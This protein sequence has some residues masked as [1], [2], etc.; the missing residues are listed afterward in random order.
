MF[1]SLSVV[2]LGIPFLIVGPFIGF[3]GRTRLFAFWT[4]VVQW[5]L[6]LVCGIRVRVEGAA[7]IPDYPVVVIANHQSSWETFAFYNLFYPIC[8]VLKRE[9]TWIPV[10][11]WLLR[12]S[13]PIIIDRRRKTTSLKEILRQGQDRLKAG[14]SVMIFPEGTRVA[15]GEQKAYLPGGAM[16]AVKA[17]VPVLPIAHNAGEHWPAHRLAKIPG[18]IV[19]SIGAPLPTQGRNAKGLNG[20]L[21]NWINGEKKRL[22]KEPES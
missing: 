8:T 10:F 13:R 18:E 7:N 15:P 2:L 20:E 3:R 9:L 19:V 21:E 1:Y 6:R 11:G 4:R 16:L 17:Q 22:T 5:I 14:L 12:W